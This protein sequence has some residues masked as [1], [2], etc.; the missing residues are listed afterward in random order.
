MCVCNFSSLCSKSLG[1]CK[2]MIHIIEIATNEKRAHVN[3][4][5]SWKWVNEGTGGHKCLLSSYFHIVN[6]L[7]F[8]LFF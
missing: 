2:I 3:E 7:S 4:S 1:K 5:A 8:I 6:A